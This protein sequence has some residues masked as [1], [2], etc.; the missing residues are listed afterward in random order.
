MSETRNELKEL[1]KCVIEQVRTVKKLFEN[2]EDGI[3]ITA[4]IEHFTQMGVGV[5]SRVCS[6]DTPAMTVLNVI[7][8]NG[9]RIPFFRSD[10]T[11]TIFV[12]EG[13]IV[14]LQTGKGTHAGGVYVVNPRR[15]FE[16][17]SDYA[18]LVVTFKPAFEE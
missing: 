12:A 6:L 5:K 7:M 18:M 10:R 2:L 8:G 13:S 16:L 9:G 11:I 3:N 17:R 1:R 14:D 15:P 4:G